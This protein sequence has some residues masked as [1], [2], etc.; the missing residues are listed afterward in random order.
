M[1]KIMFSVIAV[2]CMS[3]AVFASH[4][5]KKSEC[6]PNNPKCT[7]THAAAKPATGGCAHGCACT[8]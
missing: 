8:K 4:S 5:S 1:K 2:A 6:N 3:V 7:C